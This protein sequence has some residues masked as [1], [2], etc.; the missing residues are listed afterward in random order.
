M[1][2]KINLLLVGILLGVGLSP[3]LGETVT[4]VNRTLSAQD[5]FNE[6]LFPSPRSSTLVSG[7]SPLRFGTGSSGSELLFRLPLISAQDMLANDSVR[8]SMIL[9]ARVP[10]GGSAD[11]DL[12]IGIS[13]GTNVV[14]IMRFDNSGGG[15]LRIEYTGTSSPLT[16]LG[17]SDLFPRGA[18]FPNQFTVDLTLT[19]TATQA[20]GTLAGTSGSQTAISTLDR[21]ADLEIFLVAGDPGETYDIHSLQVTLE[22]DGVAAVPE[23]ASWLLI[24]IATCFWIRSN[25]KRN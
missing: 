16:S 20:G 24:A 3:L 17:N 12:S 14:S 15:L 18:G 23:P 6:A 2:L 1:K 25:Q 19:D 9:D 7:S 8:I 4:L 10:S 22:A 11:N 21:F 5:I 13:D